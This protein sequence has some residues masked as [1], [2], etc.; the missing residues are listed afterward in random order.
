MRSPVKERIAKLPEE[1]AA[2]QRSEP[3]VLSRRQE[4]DGWSDHER[5]LQRVQEILDE[6]AVLTDW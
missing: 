5:R 3:F 1:I 6:L 4:E 2:N